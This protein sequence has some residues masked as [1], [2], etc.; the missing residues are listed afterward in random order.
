MTETLKPQVLKYMMKGLGKYR[1]RAVFDIPVWRVRRGRYLGDGNY[2]WEP[3]RGE[4]LSLG[5]R[6]EA[7]YDCAGV[8]RADVVV[9]PSIAGKDGYLEIDFGGEA[10]VKINGKIVGAVSSGWVNRDSIYLGSLE[11]GEKL[12]IRLEYAVDAGSFCDAAMDGAKS[13]KYELKKARLM[14][15]DEVCRAF[16]TDLNIAWGALDY[17]EDEYIKTGVLQAIDESIHMVDFDFEADRVRE[18]IGRA[19]AH[20]K[21]KLVKIRHSSQSEVF[22]I[23]HSHID[24]AWLWRV[25]ETQR[26]AARTF[27]NNLALMDRYPGFVFAQ[28]QAILYEMIKEL[29]PELYERIKEKVK[30]GQWDI[31]GNVWVEADTNIASG[32]A[33][34]RQLLYGREFFKNEFGKVSDIYW[35]PDCFGF[36]RALPQIIR[37]SGMKYF[38]TAKLGSQD[39]NRFPHTNFRWSDGESGEVLAHMLRMAYGGEYLPADLKKVTDA[40]ERKNIVTDA[41]GMFGYGDGGGGCTHT[42]LEHA[43]RLENFPGLPKSRLTKPDEFFN[44]LEEH[45]ENLP[46]YKGE[47]YYENHRGTY[48]SQAYIKQNNRRGEFLLTRAEMLSVFAKG[49]FDH[50]YNK[51]ALEE[52]W[53]LLLKNQFHDILP[54]TSIHEAHEDCRPD[55]NR[56]L[57][58]GEVLEDEALMVLG[59]NVGTDKTGVLV[60]NLLSHP[61]T[62]PVSSEAFGD[63]TDICF[64]DG[65]EALPTVFFEEEGLK[66][67][68]FL[69][70]DVPPMGYKFFEMGAADTTLPKLRAQKDSLENDKLRIEIDDK[71][72]IRSIYD[73][74]NSREVLAGVGNLLTIFQDK[75]VHETAWNLELNY[76]NK[77]WDLDRADKI[78]LMEV[79][80]LRA[81]LRVIRSFNKSLIKQDYILYAGSARLDIKTEIDWYETDKLLKA[82]FE[83]DISDNKATF[84][85]AH[86]AIDRPNHWNT[87][88][89]R[90]RFE[91]CGH[92][93]ADLSEG[94]YGISLLNDS[95]YG[96][97]IKGKRMRISL[98][99]SPTCPDRTSDHGHHSFTYSLYPHKGP[100]QN[101]GTVREA[102]E[103]NLGLK[104]QPLGPQA[105]K[106]DIEQSFV[107]LNK[108]H[109]VIDTIKAAQDGKGFII[110]VY[111]AN[112]RRGP[113]KLS[114]ALPFESVYEC[115][116]M[117][118]NERFIDCSESEFEFYIKPYEVK[119]FRLL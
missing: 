14:S 8:F 70:K 106:L 9:P 61:V 94:D 56:L 38:V 79:N 77:Y 108:D 109:V 86:G 1:E 110:R 105:G 67:V 42:M 96:Y 30:N 51:Q 74:E 25:Q 98:M 5:D 112:Q 63:L 44:K 54:G 111:E 76:Q 66:K 93:W 27:S 104:A 20:L 101:G 7:S 84:E 36:S 17:I 34:I 75:C 21:E 43:K 28:S 29:Y 12:E 71:G 24:I 16:E 55:Y 64:F 47:M 60:W 81:V 102:F 49:L 91:Q 88:F 69:A 46:Q 89:D 116:L 13:V 87:D 113:V 97:D 107:S 83:V 3:D 48:T 65:E 114:C 23:G 82:A 19:A 115:D 119:S 26:K 95:K 40:N 50:R 80:P 78:E 73:K 68:S 99:R 118:E 4:M 2:E 32:E 58:L 85:T 39:T 11:G 72:L 22:M 62:G 41:L 15:A 53:K 31:V 100:W 33:L 45:F 103:L 6:W 52:A 37:R 18:S 57:A 10:L 92:K 90:A 117:E 35:L 59:A